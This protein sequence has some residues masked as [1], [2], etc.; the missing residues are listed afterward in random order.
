LASASDTSTT[1]AHDPRPRYDASALRQF[2]EAVLEHYGLSSA[3]AQLGARA[4][5]D[6]DLSGVDTHGIANFPVHLQYAKGLQSGSV[7]PRPEMKVLRDSPVAASWDSG[8]GL[9]PVVACHAMT[10]AIDKARN[11]GIGMITV[12]NGCHCGAIG[13]YAR[14]AAEHDMIG[15]VMSHSIASS[16]PP[17]GTE[18]V[19]GTNPIAFAAPVEGS[20]PLS[21]DMAT[22]LAAGLNLRVA[23]RRGVDIPPGWAVDK[24]GK[25]STSAYVREEGGS[26]LYLGATPEGGGYKGYGLAMMV[27]V[28]SGILS[29]TGSGLWQTYTPAWQQGQWFAAWRIDAFIDPVEFKAEMKRMADH[30][31]GTRPVEGQGPVAVPGDRSATLRAE[32][33]RLGV[34]LDAHII[35]HCCKLGEQAGVPFPAAL[36]G[37]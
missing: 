12:R 10:A 17:G 1:P 3:D 5:S 32:R 11:T 2:I 35:D 6:A 7:Q 8:R 34:P 22:T 23:Q 24:D 9:G 16:F 19:A 26:L 14:M 29:G 36:A 25:A 4:I 37:R 18:P 27:E 21:L 15:M 20:H 30:I 33:G 13:Y 28:V 31:R